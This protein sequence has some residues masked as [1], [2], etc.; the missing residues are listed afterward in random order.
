[1]N[2]LLDDLNSEFEIRTTHDPDSYLGIKNDPDKGIAFYKD[3]P[4]ELLVY[5]DSYFAGDPA[6]SKSIR[7]IVLWRTHKLGFK[8]TVGDSNQ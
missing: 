4:N 1:M 3:S 6:S 2:K 5:C 8:K 7:H